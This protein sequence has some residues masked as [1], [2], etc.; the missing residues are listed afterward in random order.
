M[1]IGG[2]AIAI[3]LLACSYI[4]NYWVFVF[5]YSVVIGFGF[6]LLYMVSLRNAWQFY[7]SKK[8]M[9]SGLIMSCYSVGAVLWVIL[10]KQIANPQNLKPDLN[11][12]VGDEMEHF[13]TPNSDVVKNVPMML[14]TLG[15]IYL[16]MI[17]LATIFVN[18]RVMPLNE[19]P[20]Y[21]PMIDGFS[22]VGCDT[23][24]NMSVITNPALAGTVSPLV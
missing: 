21:L 14:R 4:K 18:K 16:G 2:S 6:G 13:F 5:L 23:T 15:F 17:V 19:E 24:R 12:K 11:V 22:S 7:P 3:P 9:I 1:A 20:L 8:G 10:T